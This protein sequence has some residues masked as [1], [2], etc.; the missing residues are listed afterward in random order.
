MHAWVWVVEDSTGV[1][2]LLI[3]FKLQMSTWGSLLVSCRLEDVLS[4]IAGDRRTEGRAERPLTR[5]FLDCSASLSFVPP[6]PLCPFP[7]LL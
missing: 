3:Y 2:L 1:W 6:V 5:T 4:V 7:S